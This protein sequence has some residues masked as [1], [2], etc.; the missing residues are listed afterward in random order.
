MR[1][2]LIDELSRRDVAKIE[3]FLDQNAMR[4]ALDGIFWVRIPEDLLSEQQFAHRDCRP[5]VFAV[6]TGEDWIKLEL[7][8][9]SLAGMRC[10]CGGYATRPQRDFIIRFAHAMIR[11]LDIR[12]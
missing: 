5:H 8:L 4:S 7:F 12:T 9:R 10:P 6:E 2:Y 3:A 1:S 11:D